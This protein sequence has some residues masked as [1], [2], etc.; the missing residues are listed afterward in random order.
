VPRAHALRQGLALH[1]LR[2]ET[3]HE[4]VARAWSGWVGLF[5]GLGWVVC[6]AG[7]GGGGGLVLCVCWVGG[8]IVGGSCG[9]WV[10]LNVTSGERATPLRNRH[11]RITR[12][13]PKSPSIHPQT[14]PTHRHAPLISCI[15]THTQTH[16]SIYIYP[17]TLQ[18]PQ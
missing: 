15:C 3:A 6:G 16:T 4:G 12:P 10:S 7:G 9:V 1:E 11:N 14:P 13:P 2:E 17:Q 8:G 18:T 5:M